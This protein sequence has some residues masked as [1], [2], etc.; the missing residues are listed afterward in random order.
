MVI[1]LRVLFHIVTIFLAGRYIPLTNY[2]VH[3]GV[4][5]RKSC[6]N[7]DIFND[8]FVENDD[9]RIGPESN[10]LFTVSQLDIEIEDDDHGECSEHTLVLQ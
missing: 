10:L 3:F 9:I 6:I 4:C 7:V 1:S 2:S 8:N 5:D